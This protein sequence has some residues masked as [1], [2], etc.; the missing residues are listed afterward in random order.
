M[1]TIAETNA[2]NA[3]EVR[4]EGATLEGVVDPAAAAKT[5][6]ETARAARETAKRLAAEAAEAARLA[7]E[8]KA[9]APSA[10]TAR[11]AVR[12]VDAEILEAAGAIAARIAEGYPE[13]MR[14][15]ILALV[16]NQLHHLA[17][18]KTGWI[19]TLPVPNRSEWK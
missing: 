11:E 14:A 9:S 12:K 13:G 17:S 7:R 5:A 1:A 6:R 8:A 15:E 2:A 16:S 18:P 10:P 3:R 4:T 19:G